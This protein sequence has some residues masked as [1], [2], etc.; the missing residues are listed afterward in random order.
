V[1][2]PRHFVWHQLHIC[3]PC[4]ETNRVMNS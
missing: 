2:L 4:G 3:K 1:V